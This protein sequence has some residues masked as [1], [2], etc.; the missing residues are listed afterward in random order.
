MGKTPIHFLKK[1]WKQNATLARQTNLHQILYRPPRQLR[2][3]SWHKHDPRQPDPRT[4]GYPKLQN[5][6][7]SLEKKPCFTKNI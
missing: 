1:V 7:R 4:M 6:N 5:L 3:G 2:E